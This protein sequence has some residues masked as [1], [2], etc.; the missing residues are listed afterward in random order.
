MSHRDPI[1]HGN[2]IKPPGHPPAR[3]NAG[4]TDIGL[5][6]KRRVAR[7]AIITR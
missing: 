3:L 5:R 7:R 2:R 6:I 4:A 1:S